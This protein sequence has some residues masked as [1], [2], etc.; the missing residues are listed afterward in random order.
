MIFRAAWSCVR[1]RKVLLGGTEGRVR[2]PL[3][4]V[5]RVPQCPPAPLAAPVLAEA[6]E[7]LLDEH[8]RA[9]APLEPLLL[10]VAPEL[11]LDQDGGLR[12]PL[13]QGELGDRGQQCHSTLKQ[14]TEYHPSVQHPC[15]LLKQGG[16]GDMSVTAPS[17]TEPNVTPVSNTPVVCS[18]RA[19]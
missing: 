16:Q 11:A 2:T 3:L 15:H 1:V 12:H 4:P 13:E 5:P 14:G 7:A 8:G 9:P 6:A 18:N 10:R 17:N 19:N